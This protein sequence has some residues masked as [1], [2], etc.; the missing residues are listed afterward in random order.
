MDLLDR[1]KALMDRENENPSVLSKRSGIPYT[2]IVGLFE[3]GWERA[4]ISTIQKLSDYYNVSLDY[5]VYGAQGLSDE[6]L[7]IAS[8]IDILDDPYS[9]SLIKSVIANEVKRKNRA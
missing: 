8:Q 6:T 3:R 5:L 7:L 9:I 4:Q 2:T 1:L